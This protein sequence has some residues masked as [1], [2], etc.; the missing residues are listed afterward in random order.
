MFFVFSVFCLLI[1]V[2]SEDV[3]THT[4]CVLVKTTV[5]RTG[6]A[7]RVSTGPVDDLTLF[8][9]NPVV[10]PRL[11]L[12][13]QGIQNTLL[14][15]LWRVSKAD[16]LLFCG[17]IN[18]VLDAPCVAND[19]ELGVE[20]RHVCCAFGW[21]SPSLRFSNPLA[22]SLLDVFLEGVGVVAANSPALRGVAS[23]CEL[24]V[25]KVLHLVCCLLL[26]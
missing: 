7:G 3:A 26:W 17:N 13:C 21:N 6:V 25:R 23:D 14:L 22:A 5:D 19:L 15:G 1:L 9:A 18:L 11:C 10:L 16:T 4:E 2:P 20:R 24:D 8:A 12:D